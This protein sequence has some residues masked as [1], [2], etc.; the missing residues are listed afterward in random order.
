MKGTPNLEAARAVETPPPFGERF[1]AADWRQHHRQSRGMA[2]EVVR[3]IDGRD[4]AQH[5]GPEG[6]A[7]ERQAVAQQRRLRRRGADQIVP[8]VAIELLVRSLD[9]FM[10]RQEITLGLT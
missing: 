7:V 9:Q 3:G 5:S 4:V 8:H 1:Q 10:Q 2:E 6:D